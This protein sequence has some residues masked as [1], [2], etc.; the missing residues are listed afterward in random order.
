MQKITGEDIPS[1]LLEIPQPPQVVYIE[2][3]MPPR[4]HT[5]LAVVGSRKYTSYGKA[6]CEKL[7]ASLREYPVVIVSGLALGIDGIAHETA[8]SVGLPTVAFP[9]SGLDPRALYPAQHFSLAQRILDGGGALISEFHPEERAAP[10]TFPKRNRLMAGYCKA[11]LVVEAEEKSGS[12]ITARLATEYNRD[13]LAVPGSIFSPASRG[14][15]FLLRQGAVPIRDTGDLL[16]A[17]GLLERLSDISQKEQETQALSHEETA[18]LEFLREPL[19]KDDLI[20]ALAIPA[21]QANILI[22]VLEIKGFIT[23]SM[24]ELRRI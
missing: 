8:L 2:G 5:L 11:V 15:N 7:V 6:A 16:Q 13:V 22:S 3:T 1:Q 12:L 23:E 18:I 10:W 21:H 17:L 4:S 9:G 19:P 20:R 24:G 14:T